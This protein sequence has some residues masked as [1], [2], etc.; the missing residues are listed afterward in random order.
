M[1][2]W[3]YLTL[4]INIYMALDCNEEYGPCLT[5]SFASVRC[6]LDAYSLMLKVWTL[7]SLPTLHLT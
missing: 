5:H 2:S 7:M 6:L 3:F 1:D 4:K